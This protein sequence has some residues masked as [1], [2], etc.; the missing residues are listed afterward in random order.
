M[1]SSNNSK[2]LV[3][4]LTTRETLFLTIALIRW[5]VLQPHFTDEE[6]KAQKGKVTHPRSHSK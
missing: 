3:E 4:A 6:S 2:H 1:N 5:I